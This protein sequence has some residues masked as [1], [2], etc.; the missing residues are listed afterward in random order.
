[1]AIDTLPLKPQLS[2][3]FIPKLKYS[4]LIAHTFARKARTQQMKKRRIPA[5]DWCGIKKSLK[6]LPFPCRF[7]LQFIPACR[8]ARC[9]E[10][11]PRPLRCC[12]FHAASCKR[13]KRHAQQSMNL[14]AKSISPLTGKA[15]GVVGGAAGARRVAGG[16]D[17]RVWRWPRTQQSAQQSQ[18]HRSQDDMRR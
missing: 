7:P 14:A 4:T 15:T 6:A 8:V 3:G 17:R 18:K 12:A 13:E 2:V 5:G 16:L 11:W 9:R 1:M 10:S